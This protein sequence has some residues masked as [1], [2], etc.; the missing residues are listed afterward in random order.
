MKKIIK[1]AIS[2][3]M[4]N[5]SFKEKAK[6][7]FYNITFPKNIRFE[8]IKNGYQTVYA[9]FVDSTKMIT[10]EALYIKIESYNLYQ[11]FYKLKKGDVVIDAG[12]NFGHLSLMFSKQ[13]GA[14]GKIYS[15]E[16]DR[17]NV[18]KMKYNFQLNADINAIEII[19]LLLWS[20]N[21]VIDFYESGTVASSALWLPYPS[22]CVKKEAVKI[23]D[24]VLKN[25]IDKI[26]FIKM[27]IEGAELEAIYGCEAVIKKYAPNFAIASYHIVDGQPTYIELER[28]FKKLDY[29]C[30]TIHFTKKEIITFAGTSVK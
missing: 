17:I 1:K 29:P 15:F 21:T 6:L 18:E 11:N 14:N 19:D 20:K 25:N 23:D 22:K 26:D 5:N 8:L 9:T 30:K 24:W 3:I 28:F 27:D 16:P 10:R 13:V 2:Y 7:I 12:A 4:P